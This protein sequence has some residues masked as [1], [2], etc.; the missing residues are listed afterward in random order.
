MSEYEAERAAVSAKTARLKA[1]RL[2]RDAELGTA[3]QAAPSVAASPKK[4]PAKK[5]AKSSATLSQWLA[6]QGGSGRRS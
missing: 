3:A 2:A 1:L 4:K 5:T 6:E